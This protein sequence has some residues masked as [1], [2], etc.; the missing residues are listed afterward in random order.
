MILDPNINERMKLVN[1][2][3]AICTIRKGP[4]FFERYIIQNHI[5]DPKAEANAMVDIGGFGKYSG[6]LKLPENSIKML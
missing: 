3:P 5:T 6:R 1:L 2:K 4:S